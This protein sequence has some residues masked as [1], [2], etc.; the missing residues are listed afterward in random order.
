M[1]FKVEEVG[2]E[3]ASGHGDDGRELLWRGLERNIGR[4]GRRAWLR[5]DLLVCQRF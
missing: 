4:H 5:V 1:A 3:E 2:G